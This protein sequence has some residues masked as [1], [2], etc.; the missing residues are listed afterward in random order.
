MGK[1]GSSS[2]ELSISNS[3]HLHSLFGHSPCLVGENQRWPGLKGRVVRYVQSLVRRYAL[4]KRR[5]IKIITLVRDPVKRNI[6]MFFQE[7]PYWIVDY[8]NR[9]NPDMRQADFEF[10]LDVYRFS[11][12]HDY[13]LNWFDWELKRLTGI[14]VLSDGFDAEKGFELYEHGKYKVLCLRAESLSSVK[15]HICDFVGYQYDDFRTNDASNKWYG[16]VYSKF[17]SNKKVVY[18]LPE[19]EKVLNSRFAEVFGYS[20]D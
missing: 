7:L 17:I 13:C 15:D 1:V 6:S 4:S 10:L 16:E 3:V 8:I 12:D 18:S 20:Y 14:D 5:E 2:L 19:S 9:H 11:F